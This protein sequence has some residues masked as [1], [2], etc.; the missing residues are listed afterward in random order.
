MELFDYF[1]V[2]N[3]WNMLQK[4]LK[5]KKKYIIIGVVITLLVA[6]ILTANFFAGTIAEKKIRQALKSS[7]SGYLIDFDRAKVNFFTMTVIIKDLTIS[8]DSALLAQYKDKESRQKS[9][10]QV[11]IPVLRLRHIDAVSI[12]GTK[13]IDISEIVCNKMVLTLLTGGGKQERH[14]VTE[15]QVDKGININRIALPEIG[16]VGIGLVKFNAF[17]L[18]VVNLPKEDTVLVNKGA[19]FTLDNLSLIK[20]PLDT[21][22]FRLVMKDMRL[23][24]EDEDFVFSTKDY[25]FSFG[26]LSFSLHNRLLHIEN[27]RFSPKRNMYSMASSMKFRNDVYNLTTDVIDMHL[28]DIKSMI[29]NGSY[30]FPLVKMTGLKLFVL[31]NRSLPFD[32][33]KRPLLPNDLLKHMTTGLNIDSL[34]I[35]KSQ[36][37]YEESNSDKEP[38]MKVS[39][40]RLKVLVTGI[41]SVSDSMKLRPMKMKIEAELQNQIPMEVDFTFPLASVRDTFSYYGALGGGAM[42][43]FNPMLES[44]A[45]VKFS[46]GDL[47]SIK[48]HV[49]ANNTYAMGSMTMLYDNLNGTVLRKDGHEDNKLLSWIANQVLKS[50]NP[51]AGEQPRE[52]PIYFNRVMYKGFGNFAFKPLL[53]GILA[54]TIPTF[55]KSNQKSIDE[56]NGVTRR[57]LRKRK[58]EDKRKNN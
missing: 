30:D 18:Y 54:T 51:A 26:R 42:S 44:A 40:D 1:R 58:R 25:H 36:L 24:I 32:E 15:E 16:G 41:T 33:S 46:S 6:I 49:R 31:R 47:K 37:V 34:I 20:N 45:G 2:S 13:Q 35:N 52:V 23:D 57:D 10:Y 53:S 19:D 14:R 17:T 8:P 22:T 50:D 55:D 5:P 27:A 28:G 21:N 43:V 38:T 48:F 39:L 29:L 56:I 7:D 3:V 4:N 12:L 11:E 9:L